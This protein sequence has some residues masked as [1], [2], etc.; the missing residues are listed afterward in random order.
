MQRF[1]NLRTSQRISLKFTISTIVVILGFAVIVNTIVFALWYDKTKTFLDDITSYRA[2][3]DIVPSK[4]IF[5]NEHIQ[6]WMALSLWQRERW[7]RPKWPKKLPPIEIIPL[8]SPKAQAIIHHP[9][10]LS[11]TKHDDEWLMYKTLGPRLITVSIDNHMFLQRLLLR[12]S[13]FLIIAFACIS[14]GLSL[15]FVKS[16]LAQLHHVIAQIQ[17][18][19]IIHHFSPIQHDWPADDEIRIV[20]NTLN[21]A[22]E[23]I[24]RDA[25]T[26]K[27]FIAHAAH[28]LKTPLMTMSSLIDVATQKNTTDSLPSQLKPILHAQS[29]LI[30][31]LLLLAK[32]EHQHS[33]NF[34]RQQTNIY[35]VVTPLITETSTHYQTKAINTKKELSD[36]VMVAIHRPSFE[37]LVKNLLDNAYSYTPAH[38]TVTISLDAH[39]LRITDTGKGIA[40][41]HLDHIREKFWR[42]DSSQTTAT[43][44]KQTH[45]GL[46]LS[47]CQT[48][49]RLHGFTLTVDS[50]LGTWTTFTLYFS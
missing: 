40:S 29:E 3:N 4:S 12:S 46:W 16:T 49:A 44:G 22:L 23:R 31:Q 18:K 6:E 38:G 10:H 28:E 13:F 45:Y 15:L 14:Y 9:W 47:L 5:I 19:D 37:I 26:L 20:V 48:I 7:R 34:P 11:I 1:R 43:E 50:T 25:Q 33:A 42:A 39:S 27:N 41:E 36:S 35:D 2:T 21:T 30:N 32:Y 8:I 17:G 24:H